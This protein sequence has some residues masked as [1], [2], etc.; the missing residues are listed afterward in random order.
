MKKFWF[1]SLAVLAGFASPSQAAPGSYYVGTTVASNAVL[2]VYAPATNLVKLCYSTTAH[3]LACTATKPVFAAVPPP[4]TA[5]QYRISQ[6]SLT[7]GLWILDMT[8][9]RQAL[10]EAALTNVYTITCT[11]G[12]GLK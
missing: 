2:W 8:A 4:A 9:N 6:N 10:C 5:F 3:S 11:L 7:G 12:S 1:A